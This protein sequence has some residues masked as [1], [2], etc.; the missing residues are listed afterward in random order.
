M[1]MKELTAMNT[2][3]LH[4]ALREKRS[5]LRELKFKVA[6]DEDKQVRKVRVLRNDI[7]RILT[8]LNTRKNNS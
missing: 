7:A 3:E 8:V 2:Q 1:D 6:L 4:D 5:E